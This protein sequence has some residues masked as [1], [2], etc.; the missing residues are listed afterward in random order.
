MKTDRIA[1]NLLFFIYALYSFAVSMPSARSDCY[2][3]IKY[4][5]VRTVIYI[6]F[7]V[8]TLNTGKYKPIVN[9]ILLI[10]ILFLLSV[11]IFKMY[12]YMKIYHGQT[13]ALPVLFISGFTI[14]LLSEL[15]EQN[16]KQL[17]LPLCVVALMMII[18]VLIL[19]TDKMNR[20]NLFDKQLNKTSNFDI[21]M[22]DYLVPY[23]IVIR[24]TGNKIKKSAITTIL[25]IVT[26]LTLITIFAFMTIRGDLLYSLSP[27]Q[28][29]FRM[30]STELIRNFDALYN[31]FVLFLYFG[32]LVALILSYKSVKKDFQYFNRSDLLSV[33]PFYVLISNFQFST[34]LIEVIF[35]ILMF[36]GSERKGNYEKATD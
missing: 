33:I 31:Y 36:I 9:L 24:T 10:Y 32:A 30:S 8:F 16:L 15:T 2:N 35:M 18:T 17:H 3:W 1:I 5:A 4:L 27:L 25:G 20:F 23:F 34:L 21:T 29:V 7:T 14:I 6:I 13:T 22:F 26:S 12:S 11:Q 28:I 19:N